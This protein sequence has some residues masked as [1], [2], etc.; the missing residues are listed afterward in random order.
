[1]K[2]SSFVNIIGLQLLSAAAQG[3]ALVCA[4]TARTAEV[5]AAGSL[6]AAT[7]LRKEEVKAVVLSHGFTA[8]A[9]VAKEARLVRISHIE[10]AREAFRLARQSALEAELARIPMRNVTPKTPSREIDERAAMA[11]AG[12]MVLS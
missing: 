2:T 9:N 11:A 6:K 10:A 1:M 7:Y 3:V 12:P 8:A 4:G 5:T